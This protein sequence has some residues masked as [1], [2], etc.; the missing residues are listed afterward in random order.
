MWLRELKYQIV[1][2]EE[3]FGHYTQ[4]VMIIVYA[5]EHYKEEGRR[6]LNFAWL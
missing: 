4:W 2:L 3:V 5:S 1:A 6:R